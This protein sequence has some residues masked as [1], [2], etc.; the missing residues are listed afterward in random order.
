MNGI[1]AKWLGDCKGEIPGTVDGRKGCF[2]LDIV[3][4]LNRQR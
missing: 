4:G 2:V 3:I 1:G